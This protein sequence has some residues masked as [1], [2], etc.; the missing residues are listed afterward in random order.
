MITSFLKRWRLSI[1][2]L[3]AAWRLKA[4]GERGRVADSFQSLFIALKFVFMSSFTLRVIMSTLVSQR[5][6]RRSYRPPL[7]F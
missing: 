6:A 3:V 1:V 5:T 7:R 2:R 4:L